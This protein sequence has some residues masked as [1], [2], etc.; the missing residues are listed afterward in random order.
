MSIEIPKG[1][2]LKVGDAKNIYAVL[3]PDTA[4]ASKVSWHTTNPSVATVTGS[5]NKYINQSIGTV[6]AIAPGE[7][8]I[9]ASVTSYI[10][11][12]AGNTVTTIE[13]DDSCDV[14]VKKVKI[15]L[16]PE[17]IEKGKDMPG[18]EFYEN[19]RT[20]MIE[21]ADKVSNYLIERGY[22]VTIGRNDAPSKEGKEYASGRV[23][24]SNNMYD[25]NPN[26]INLHVCIHSNA[27][28]GRGPEVYT[29]ND[30]VAEK[31]AQRVQDRLFAL[32]KTSFPNAVNRGLKVDNYTEL[33]YTKATAIYVETAYHDHLEDAYWIINNMSSIAEAIG[34]GIIDYINSL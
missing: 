9:K 7:A 4:S 23:T 18:F 29:Y 27:G 25:S 2:N 8:K 13:L 17:N 30:T 20:R 31:L 11:N 5:L 10:T 32:Y 6:R 22:D 12:S 33:V 1:I 21:L 3:S 34:K 19:E 28:G 15:Y 16:S 26:G 14:T 24:E